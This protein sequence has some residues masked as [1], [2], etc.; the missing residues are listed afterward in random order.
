MYYVYELVLTGLMM[1]KVQ[2][3]LLMILFFCKMS[4]ET[5][6]EPPHI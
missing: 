1:R 4:C 6:F 2:A 5:P 3:D